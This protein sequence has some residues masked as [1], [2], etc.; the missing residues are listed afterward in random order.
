[1][2]GEKR[3][4][5]P[6]IMTLLEAGCPGLCQVLVDHPEIITKME[7]D[8]DDLPLGVEYTTAYSIR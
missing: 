6:N 5:D 2:E 4:L 7:N 3:I 1:M 8:E